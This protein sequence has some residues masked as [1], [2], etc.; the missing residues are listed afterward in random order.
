MIG[1]QV[2]FELCN[3][4]CRDSDR[5]RNSLVQL[6]L[7]LYRNGFGIHDLRV[8][9]KTREVWIAFIGGNKNIILTMMLS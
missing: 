4:L 9:V 7:D 1:V 3:G 2:L 6:E 8:P 5:Y